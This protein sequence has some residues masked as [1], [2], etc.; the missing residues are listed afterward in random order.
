MASYLSKISALVTVNTGQARQALSGF[1]GDAKGF[2]QSLDSTF[3]R[4][5]ANTSR[6]FD[7]IWTDAQKLRRM[8]KAGIADGVDPSTLLQFANTKRLETEMNKIAELRKRAM[9]MQT[10]GFGKAAHGEVDKLAESFTKLHDRVA[11]T[12]QLSKSALEQLKR[13]IEAAARA[14][15]TL[16]KKDARHGTA[17]A[18]G[19]RYGLRGQRDALEAH[20]LMQAE[21]SM[22]G[23]Q[24]IMLRLGGG[25][26]DLKRAF[27]E[28]AKVQQMAAE[29][30]AAGQGIYQKELKESL[31]AVLKLIAAQAKAMGIKDLSNPAAVRA[32]MMQM[33]G[34]QQ[35]TG[36]MQAGMALSQLTY[37]L[38]D[39]MSATGGVDQKI[40]AMGNNISQLGFIAGGTAGLIAGVAFNFAA[41]LGVALWKQMDIT[42]DSALM[43]KQLAEAEKELNAARQKSIEI[44]DEIGDSLRRAGLSQN[45]QRDLDAEQR[46]KDYV[47][48]QRAQALGMA[49]QY[50]PELRRMR[51]QRIKND[52]RLKEDISAGER[53]E[54]LRENESLDRQMRQ[55][56]DDLLSGES[57]VQ[58]RDKEWREAYK[59]GSYTTDLSEKLMRRL[60]EIDAMNIDS[61]TRDKLIADAYVTFTAPTYGERGGAPGIMKYEQ[62]EAV[63]AAGQA[64]EARAVLRAAEQRAELMPF[65]DA[66][67][68]KLQDLRSDLDDTFD[69][70]VPPML[71]SVMEGFSVAAEDI[72]RRL[73]EGEITT[74]QAMAELNGLNQEMDEFAEANNIVADSAREGAKALLEWQ[75]AHDRAIE[76][77]QA[78]RQRDLDNFVQGAEALG[79]NQFSQVANIERVASLREGARIAGLDGPEAEAMIGEIIARQVA[80]MLVQMENARMNAIMPGVNRGAMTLEDISTTGGMAEFNRLLRGDD[81]AKDQDLMELRKQTQLLQDIKE[82]TGLVGV[83]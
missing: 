8:M 64:D 21:R 4:M 42:A 49:E 9:G 6:S 54:L 82:D 17:Q 74:E 19:S 63:V 29:R 10:G 60:E 69:G 72:F 46:R 41:Q 67:G 61:K 25:T 5:T 23:L 18:I 77:A 31:D 28:L 75:K 15:T 79:N 51:A 7:K 32:Q 2:A 83:I 40:R 1:A 45:Q 13:D 80:P 39:F 16:E 20:A 73:Q 27:A 44:I 43:A 22:A 35:N 56:R 34:M 26:A 59:K 52:Q 57:T 36:G 58:Q 11:T 62:A 55:R 33:S 70:A 3:A 48:S 38:D 76:A 66:A 68:V 50:D 14:M 78:A 71:D 47:E 12:G 30:G 53:V 37:A 65:F 81:S 24:T